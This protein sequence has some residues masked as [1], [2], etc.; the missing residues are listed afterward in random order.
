MAIRVVG[1]DLYGTLLDLDA[2]VEPLRAHT[3]M[4]EALA[5][6][7]RQRQ[8]QLA[9]AT[10]SS[11][12]YVDFDRVTFM[13]LHE[14]APRFHTRLTPADQ[15]QLIDQWAMAPAHVDAQL[16]LV[17]VA[18]RRLPSIVITNAREATAKNA[19][20]HAELA[21]YVSHIYSADAV[22]VYKPNGKVYAQVE[23]DLGVDPSEILYV[24]ALD[25]DAMGGRQAGFHSIWVNRRRAGMSPRPERTIMTL[26]ELPNLLDEYLLSRT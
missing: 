15:K 25:Y 5:D 24:T 11:A 21:P 18:Q 7:W 3:P 19:L 10:T 12:R 14:T 6:A 23:A 16:A 26:G 4:A 17:A 20:E 1:F 9:N 8:L 2:I 22:K 13:A